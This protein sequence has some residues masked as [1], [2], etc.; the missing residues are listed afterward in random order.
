LSVNT[1]S[2]VEAQKDMLWIK[3]N[4][5]RLNLKRRKLII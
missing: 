5:E 3:K 4:L 1:A 2:F